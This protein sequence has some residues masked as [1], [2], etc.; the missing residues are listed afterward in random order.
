V[1]LA[2]L[3]VGCATAYQPKGFKGGYNDIQLDHDTVRVSF[4]GNGYTS[5]DTV[6]T[7]ALY[8]C[9]E[10]TLKYGYDYFV[11]VNNSE[12]AS[13][14]T[15]NTGGTYSSTTNAN[16][17]GYGSATAHTTGTYSPGPSIPVRK[18]G[19]TVIIKMFHGKK[20]SKIPNAYDARELKG[21][22]EEHIKR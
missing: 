6:A 14:F 16:V 20:P 22:L 21:Y 15:V 10:V 3:F 11:I 13:H 17:T 7:Y 19:S 4:R 18:Y 1:L 2:L 9:A 8:R 5:L 12:N